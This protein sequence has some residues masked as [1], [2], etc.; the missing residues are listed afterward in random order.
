[1]AHLGAGRIGQAQALVAR[2]AGSGEAAGWMQRYGV[3]LIEGFIAFRTGDFAAAA[4]RLMQAR[5]IAGA[6]GG[7]HA[8]RDV[9]DWTLAEA[10]IRGRMPGLARALAQERLATRPHSAV[11]RG[12]LTRAVALADGVAGGETRAAAGADAWRMG[13]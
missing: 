3:P 6:F 9:I 4:E 11:N 13:I 10:A 2:A 7:S 12:F 5:H 1:M 8:Q